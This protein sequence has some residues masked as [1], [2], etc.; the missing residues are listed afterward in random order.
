[1]K[2][3][4]FFCLIAFV[5]YLPLKAQTFQAGLRAGINGSQV[6]GDTY[7]GF[8]KAGFCGGGFSRFHL[9]N[10]LYGQFEILYSQK[11]SR[12]IPD[13]ENGDYV[14]FIIRL[15]YVEVPLL[16]SLEN[17]GFIYEGGASLAL[18]INATERVNFVPVGMPY[19]KTDVG[20][21]LGIGRKLGEHFNAQF[22]WTNSILPVRKFNVYYQNW[23]F[24]LFNKGYYNNVIYL[25]ISYTFEGR[26]E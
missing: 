3:I 11:G 9:Q 14:D 18:L 24:N 2:K 26:N 15:N 17:K 8:H 23:F 16:L 10:R 25:N 19:E 20:L 12:K 7:S 6:H 1:M 5:L 21:V 4:L 13:P 22:R